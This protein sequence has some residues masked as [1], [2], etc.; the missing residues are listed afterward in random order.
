MKWK[1]YFLSVVFSVVSLGLSADSS[2]LPALEFEYVYRDNEFIFGTSENGIDSK[3]YIEFLVSEEKTLGEKA[4]LIAALASYFEFRGQENED[5]FEKY[6]YCFEEYLQKKY[7]IE[8]IDSD[9]IPNEMKFLKTLMNDYGSFHPNINGYDKFAE[10]IP[11]SLTVQTVKVIAF[12]YDIVYN[13]S[14][15]AMLPHFIEKYEEN[16]LNPYKEH[17]ENYEQDINTK[18][19]DYVESWRQYMS[20]D[21]WEQ[22]AIVKEHSQ[23]N[24]R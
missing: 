11:Q 7:S 8:S 1:K 4:A 14:H 12:A 21:D 24:I 18:A 2:F 20:D 3:S 5:Y 10:M 23:T 22:E 19:L 9:M 13:K 16:Y 6:S 17:F 15:H